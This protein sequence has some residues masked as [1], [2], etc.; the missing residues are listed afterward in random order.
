MIQYTLLICFNFNGCILFADIPPLEKPI[1]QEPWEEN[2][3]ANTNHITTSAMSGT[4]SL[5]ER[6]ILTPDCIINL[7]YHKRGAGAGGREGQTAQIDE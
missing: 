1:K 4:R 5:Q 2:E 3:L 7:E 6:H